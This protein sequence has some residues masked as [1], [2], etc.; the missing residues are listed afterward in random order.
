MAR[1]I[2]W[3]PECVPCDADPLSGAGIRQRTSGPSLAH[4]IYWE[5]LYTTAGG[6][7]I[8]FARSDGP[9]IVGRPHGAWVCDLS[10]GAT[11]R[12]GEAAAFSGFT[13]GN[14]RGTIYYVRHA[15]GEQDQLVRL[16]LKATRRQ[17]V[18]AFDGPFLAWSIAISPEGEA[19][20]F[21]RRGGEGLLRW[22][23]CHGPPSAPVRLRLSGDAP[24]RAREPVRDPR[25]PSRHLQFMPRRPRSALRRPRA[26]RLSG[27]PCA[28]A[29]S[30]RR[31]TRWLSGLASPLQ[32][33]ADGATMGARSSPAG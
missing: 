19:L 18:Y 27:C 16:D 23:L 12:M 10:S 31:G 22:V 20:V 24:V 28:R 30:V 6:S 5:Q 21:P 33:R 13:S 25:Q 2:R 32:A 7:R 11:A 9:D 4:N 1:G 8:A 15:A 14:C 17:D 29:R 26:G 3:V